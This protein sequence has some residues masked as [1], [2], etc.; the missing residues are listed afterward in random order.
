ML[1]GPRDQHPH[2]YPFFIVSGL[3]FAEFIMELMSREV[4]EEDFKARV[5][6]LYGILGEIIKPPLDGIG[7]IKTVLGV[8]AAAGFLKTDTVT[9]IICR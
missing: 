1:K 5:K 4:G 7:G 8:L 9:R 3:F 2:F 6:A